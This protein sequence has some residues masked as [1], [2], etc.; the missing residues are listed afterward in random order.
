MSVLLLYNRWVLGVRGWGGG[1]G[2]GWGCFVGGVDALGTGIG[3][4]HCCNGGSD[5]A[6][7]GRGGGGFGWWVV[8]GG[9]RGWIVYVG[10]VVGGE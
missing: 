2:G 1:W 3:G 6:G 8:L 10:G 4:I 5:V 7:R 9:G